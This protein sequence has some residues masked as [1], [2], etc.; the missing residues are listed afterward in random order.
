MD[1]RCAAVTEF[2]KD[3]SENIECRITPIYDAF[4]PSIV[5]PEIE[6]IVVTEETCKG[7]HM[8]NEKRKVVQLLQRHFQRFFSFFQTVSTNCP[9]I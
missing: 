3:V 4:G 2:I 8:V 7:G 6:C 5:D 9:Q 1:K